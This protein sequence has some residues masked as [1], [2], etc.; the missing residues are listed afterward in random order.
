MNCGGW[1]W[2]IINVN[3]SRSEIPQI[4]DP[5]IISLSDELIF[6]YF[7]DV[8]ERLEVPYSSIAR[9]LTFNEILVEEANQWISTKEYSK[10]FRNLF[11]V[12]NLGGKDDPAMVAS[13]MNCLFLDGKKNFDLG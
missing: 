2:L 9:I 7:Q 6:E 12:Y 5:L 11:R 13:M 10:A 4:L 3:V 8:D 1:G